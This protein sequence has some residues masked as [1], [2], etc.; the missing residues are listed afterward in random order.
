ML[1]VRIAL[2]R[3]QGALNFEGWPGPHFKDNTSLG[4]V[5]VAGFLLGV[6]GGI[7]MTIAANCIINFSNSGLSVLLQ[8]AVYFSIL[9]SFHFLEFFVTAVR[10]HRCQ[11]CIYIII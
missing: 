1:T 10:Q 7:H 4:R 6:L 3:I 9:C 2:A 5:G 8:W 11:Y